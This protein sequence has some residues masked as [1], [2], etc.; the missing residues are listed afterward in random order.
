MDCRHRQISPHSQKPGKSFSFPLACLLARLFLALP[1]PESIY[2]NGDPRGYLSRRVISPFSRRD[3]TWRLWPWVHSASLK[4]RFHSSQ[5]QSSLPPVSIV[6][7]L[8]D[9]NRGSS[10]VYQDIH[11]LYHPH[12]MRVIGRPSTKIYLRIRG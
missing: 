12:I 2:C 11:V 7:L 8:L 3:D 5:W 10:P 4:Q 6:K 9:E 1:L